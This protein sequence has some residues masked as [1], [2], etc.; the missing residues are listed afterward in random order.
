MLTI[1]TTHTPLGLLFLAVFSAKLNGS[2]ALSPIPYHD[3]AQLA[4]LPRHEDEV[5]HFQKLSLRLRNCF[6]DTVYAIRPSTI[7]YTLLL[8][9]PSRARISSLSSY[10]QAGYQ[11]SQTRYSPTLTPLEHMRTFG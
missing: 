2:V 6:L 8:Y 3:A 4:Q 11:W 5:E 9:C 10:S 1:N 7:N